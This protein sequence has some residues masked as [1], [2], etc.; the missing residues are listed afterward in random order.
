MVKLP[1]VAMHDLNLIEAELALVKKQK[2]EAKRNYLGMSS[3]GDPC[4][5]KL[6]YSYHDSLQE[7]FDAATIM[8]FEDGHRSED[9]MAQRLK[10]AEGILLITTND[11]GKQF[12][13]ED[14]DGKFKGHLDG[15]ISGLKQVPKKE[16]IWEGKC[17]NEK[18]FKNFIDLKAQVGEK[19]T[20]ARWDEVYYAQAQSY[21][22]YTG[23]DRHYLTVCT[24][25]GRD[26][27][28]VRTEYD[29]EAFQKIR[30]KAG[31]ILNAKF[32]LAKLSN[33]PNWFQCKWCNYWDR[34]HGTETVSERSNRLN[35]RV[36]S[37]EKRQPVSRNADGDR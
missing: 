23:I 28:A 8:R 19:N 27:E 31:R 24:P 33:D 3:I 36:F 25:G 15:I 34:C 37:N 10:D 29:D 11:D 17:V 18:K 9:L 4:S 13:V 20:L 2:L 35:I 1:P 16:H 22:G 30:D 21:M 32:P 12:E 7:N 14:F 26:W 5:R 6:W